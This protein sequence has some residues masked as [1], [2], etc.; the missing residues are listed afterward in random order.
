[1]PKHNYKQTLAVWRNRSTFF[2]VVVPDNHNHIIVIYVCFYMD[3]ENSVDDIAGYFERIIEFDHPELVISSSKKQVPNSEIVLKILQ[4]WDSDESGVV[5][6]ASLMTAKYLELQAA[7]NESVIYHNRVV[8]ELGSGTGFLGLWL[9]AM[10]ANVLLTDLPKNL[11]LIKRN[12]SLNQNLLFGKVQIAPFD[13]L[14]KSQFKTNLFLNWKDLDQVDLF[15]VS[16]CIYY[17]EV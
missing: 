17:N 12:L 3:T 8:I 4:K 1:M 10:G 11:D 16:D 7:K 14:D 6:D 2:C 9:A 13:W 15:I 5:W